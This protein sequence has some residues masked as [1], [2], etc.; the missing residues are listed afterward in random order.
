MYQTTIN[1]E[2]EFQGIGLHTGIHT[3]LKI[4]P[5]EDT[6]IVFRINKY[7]IKANIENLYE[8]SKRGTTLSCYG[9]KIYT[10]EHILS[11]LYGLEIDNAIIEIDNIEIPILDGS[12][13][14][15]V[16]KI[17]SVGIRKLNTEKENLIIS[18]NY[19]VPFHS[20]KLCKNSDLIIAKHT[21]LVDECLSY[22]YP[23][24]IHDYSHNYISHI[25]I[26]FD[27]KNSPIICHNY[28]QLFLKVKSHLENNENMLNQDI[29]KA[30]TD[31]F[32]TEG[33]GLVKNKIF[34]ILN[35]I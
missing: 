26:T 34:N 11:A 3:K 25:S 6:G 30:H 31:F 8:S 1:H 10:V 21:S 27:Y 19:K 7:H 32:Q 23:V 4:L 17:L 20:Y 28:Q 2:V 35:R 12:N 18:T 14:Q 16:E 29:E 33:E 5:S 22:K 24:L 13:K 15:Y 9:Q